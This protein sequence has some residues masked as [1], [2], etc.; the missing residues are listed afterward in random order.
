MACLNRMGV[1]FLFDTMNRG[2]GV[3]ASKEITEKQFEKLM[4]MN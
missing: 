1:L 3:L 4:D 2:Q